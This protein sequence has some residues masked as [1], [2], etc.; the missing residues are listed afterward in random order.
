MKTS[1]GIEEAYKNIVGPRW[2]N[3][4]SSKSSGGNAGPAAEIGQMHKGLDSLFSYQGVKYNDLPSYK[5]GTKGGSKSLDRLAQM[6]GGQ[7]YNPNQ[8]ARMTSQG[9]SSGEYPYKSALSAQEAAA[10]ASLQKMRGEQETS[11]AKMRG[12]QESGLQRERFAQEAAQ[13]KQQQIAVLDAQLRS[14]N[15]GTPEFFALRDQRNR[16]R[17]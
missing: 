17:M 15:Y 2:A 7:I 5:F 8:Y 12:E 3:V 1:K 6:M 11:L 9:S 16:L 10:Q 14:M 4:P 13:Q